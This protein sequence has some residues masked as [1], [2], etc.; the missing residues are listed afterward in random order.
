MSGA[1]VFT[2]TRVPL[3]TFFDYLEGQEGF[4]EFVTDFPHLKTQAIQ[5]LEAI[6]QVM[7]YHE[8]HSSAY[9]A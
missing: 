1:I 5:V 9:S 2:G 6:A 7:L 8:R 3:Q 4:A